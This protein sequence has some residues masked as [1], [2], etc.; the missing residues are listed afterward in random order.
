MVASYVPAVPNE[1]EPRTRLQAA[2]DAAGREA[3]DQLT[4]VVV[5]ELANPIT[6]ILAA[7]ET[8]QTPGADP[9]LVHEMARRGLRQAE[10]VVELLRDLREGG[11][12]RGVVGVD[13]RR[14]QVSLAMLVRDACATVGPIAADRVVL[15]F[16]DDLMVWTVPS[17]LR[18][19]LINLIGNASK[20]ATAGPITV[21]A[22]IDESDVHVDVLDRG[23]GLPP[24]DPEQLFQ[25]FRQGDEA[26]AEGMGVGLHVVR[27]LAHSLGGDA[28]LLDREGGG[29]VARLVLP[30]RRHRP[31]S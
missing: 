17:R 18:Q 23:P 13:T 27:E 12:I 15:S 24:G 1:R 20:Y 21:E 31:T 29:T 28:T 30:Q 14:H 22:R 6:V 11:G 10:H 16:S 25:L 26:A 5:H 8:L 4:R 7:F 9:E 3:A 19:I 2:A